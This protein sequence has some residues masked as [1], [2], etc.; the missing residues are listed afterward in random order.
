M[1]VTAS[2]VA[3]VAQCRPSVVL[4]ATLFLSSSPASARGQV[5]HTFLEN[6]LNLGREAALDLVPAEYLE[7]CEVIDVQ[8]LPASK[9]DQWA[10]EVALAWDWSTGK[11][12][13]L[14]RGLGRD[15][16]VLEGTEVAGT[17]DTLSL[18]AELVHVYDYKTGW[19]DLGPV[20]NSWQLRTYGLMAARTY[21]KPAA[22]IGF[23]RLRPDG[24]PW[25]DTVTMS[26]RELDAFEV[27]LRTLL[28]EASRLRLADVRNLEFREGPL[29]RF[30]PGFSRCPAKVSLAASL[31]SPNSALGEITPEVAAKA[32]ERLAL[33]RDVLDQ[34]E[35]AVREYAL[36]HPITL[37]N[38][39]T[40]GPVEV[41]KETVALVDEA[42]AWLA[43]EFGPDVAAEA[44]E[45]KRTMTWEGLKDAL[46]PWVERTPGA[47]ITKVTTTVRE[48][49]RG[50]A[51]D[52]GRSVV[53]VSKSRVVKEHKPKQLKEGT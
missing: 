21:D 1:K 4:P 40:L 31:A 10:A 33:A 28:E 12:R 34:V 42:Q 2:S 7:T 23:I 46:R 13:E 53:A 20:L 51:T 41:A 30:C 36:H 37:S 19:A 15:Y 52:D 9:P 35:S 44:V 22:E 47:G 3:R 49:L 6:C 18:S 27:E 32:W 48:R 25:F 50:L 43:K 16:E 17:L 26:E 11:A 14:G 29:C 8:R 39:K 5:I 45:V 38:G 24:T